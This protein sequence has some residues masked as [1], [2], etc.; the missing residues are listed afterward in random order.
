MSVV[1]K[2]SLREVK[3]TFIHALNFPPDSSSTC[4]CKLSNLFLGI[5]TGLKKF[6]N[7][8]RISLFLSSKFN[9]FGFCIFKAIVNPFDYELPFKL[10]HCCTYSKKRSAHRAIP[11][12]LFSDTDKISLCRLKQLEQFQ[13]VY[14]RTSHTRKRVHQHSFYLIL[15]HLFEERPL[16]P[17]SPKIL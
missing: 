7:E 14:C 10:R 4:A 5:L 11:L 1:K 13:Q 9:T 17:S 2:L 8:L 3:V 12:N 6:A 16:T 15:L